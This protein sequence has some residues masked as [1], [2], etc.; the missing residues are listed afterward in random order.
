M[1]SVCRKAEITDNIILPGHKFHFPQVIYIFALL[2]ISKVYIQQGGWFKYVYNI[3]S[4]AKDM[5][6]DYSSFEVWKTISNRDQSLK[7]VFSSQFND[8]L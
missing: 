6:R 5:F 4:T 7:N 8:F 3:Q 2:Y 1:K